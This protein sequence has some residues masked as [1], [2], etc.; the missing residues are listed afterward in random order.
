L[1]RFRPIE[2]EEDL[3]NGDGSGESFV[4]DYKSLII[5]DAWW[6][7]AKDI[8]ALANHVGGT[9]II[10]AKEPAPGGRPNYHGLADAE[11]C[12]AV[13]VAYE[14]AAREH[15]LPR[16]I[17]RPVSIKLAT[18]VWVVAV[19]VEPFP[20]APVGA[21]APGVNRNNHPETSPA[22]SFPIRVGRHTQW[23]TPDQLPLL[24]DV[25]IRRAI[26]LLEA[27]PIEHKVTLWFRHPRNPTDVRVWPKPLNGMRVLPFRNVIEVEFQDDATY[28][29]RIPLEHIDAVWEAKDGE[30]SVLLRGHFEGHDYVANP[31]NAWFR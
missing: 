27:I 25:K 4:L 29:R 10:G 11:T 5:V 12:E 13:R 26:V 7:L 23:I 28:R 8:A 24:T 19:N 22:F 30:W 2:R 9:L 14:Q 15:C 21:R 31:S 18:G 3:P 6:E 16:P 20:D 17:V 1:A